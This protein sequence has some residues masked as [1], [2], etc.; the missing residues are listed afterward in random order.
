MEGSGIFTLAGQGNDNSLQTRR[1]HASDRRIPSFGAKLTGSTGRLTFGTLTAL[2]QDPGRTLLPEGD[3]GRP[4]G[5]A[6][7]RRFAVSTASARAITWAAL[8]VDTEYAGGFNRV[9]GA[10]L[11]WRVNSTQRV[12]GFVL[13]S[14]SRDPHADGRRRRNRRAGRL[15]IQH[16]R[17]SSSA[18]T[19]STTTADFQMETAFI[20][21]V[22]ITSGWGYAEYSFYPD[23]TKY[24]W[25]RKISPFSFTQGARDRNAKGNDLVQVSGIRLYF[26]RQG[27]FRFDRLDGYEPWAGQQ[28]DRGNWRRSGRSPTLSVALNRRT[29]QVRPGGLLRS[30]RD[31][32]RAARTRPAS[33]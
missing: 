12:T 10:D 17:G 30:R 19:A 28:F 4:K 6:L 1:P 11:S 26:T 20:N 8:V 32:S 33:G 24:P 2:D 16:A 7:Q 22:G 21:R 23:K 27:F 18:V 13:G 29:A 25:L 31:R 5:S 9:V 14:S 15:R 3:P